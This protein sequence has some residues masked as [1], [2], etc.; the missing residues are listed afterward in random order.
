MRAPRELYLPDDAAQEHD[1][2]AAQGALAGELAAEWSAH[3]AGAQR[4]KPPATRAE[5]DDETR[6]RLR[7]LGYDE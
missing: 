5:I 3:A 6:E 2:F 7:A 4:G 1:R